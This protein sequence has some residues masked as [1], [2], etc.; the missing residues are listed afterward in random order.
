MAQIILL[1]VVHSYCVCVWVIISQLSKW[2]STKCRNF[3]NSLQ[4]RQ[5]VT[6][7]FLSFSCIANGR[8][9]L[10]EPQYTLQFHA[11]HPACPVSLSRKQIAP[12]K[13]DFEPHQA[14]LMTCHTVRKSVPKIRRNLIQYANVVATRGRILSWVRI[15]DTKVF[16]EN[17]RRLGNARWTSIEDA[18]TLFR[19]ETWLFHCFG[20]CMLARPK[21]RYVCA[22]YCIS[23]QCSSSCCVKMHLKQ[24]QKRGIINIFCA[25][26][27]TVDRYSSTVL[28]ICKCK[29]V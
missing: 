24:I 4:H 13:L 11:T 22:Q 15:C 7:S 19:S 2:L 25:S 17:L 1:P 27:Y 20:I 16:A 10:P 5:E 28:C 12:R 8:E 3:C 6:R 21:S 14:K 29:L 26:I 18:A 9:V 23:T